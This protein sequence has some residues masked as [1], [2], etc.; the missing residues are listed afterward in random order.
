MYL[1]N[2][3]FNDRFFIPIDVD[4]HQVPYRLQVVNFL[5]VLVSK[6]NLTYGVLVG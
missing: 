2:T 1:V 4:D 3:F 5:L 6:Y